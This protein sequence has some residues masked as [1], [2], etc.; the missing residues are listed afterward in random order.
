MNRNLLKICAC[1]LLFLMV[2]PFDTQILSANETA[3]PSQWPSSP[4]ASPKIDSW[5]NAIRLYGSDRYQTGLASAYTM[6][7]L[8]QYPFDSPDP[9][10][11]NASLL[12]YANDWLGL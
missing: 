9:T 4:D 5:N 12:K 3:N 6:R 1:C 10:S 7:G 8:G 11:Q 2:V